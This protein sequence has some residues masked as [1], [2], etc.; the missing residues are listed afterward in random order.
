MGTGDDTT[1]SRLRLLQAEMSDPGRQKNQAAPHA[2]CGARCCT[3]PRPAHPSAPVSLSF[4]DYMT[5]AIT[6]V[7]T[8]ARADVPESHPDVEPAPG[9]PAALYDWWRSMPVEDEERQSVRD[10][11]IYRHGLE[12]AIAMGDDKVVR[13]HPC[14]ECGCF[15]LLWDTA[16]RKAICTNL[17]CV[18]DQGLTQAWEL[19][20]LAHEHITAKKM[21]KRRAT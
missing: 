15:G 17:D 9:D 19:K 12:H 1:A 10:Q 13:P 21:L 7:V 14:P 2:N 8:E 16:R 20:R 4:V 3:S 18:D 11:V 6:E 5:A